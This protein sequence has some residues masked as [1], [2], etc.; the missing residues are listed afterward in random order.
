MPYHCPRCGRPYTT[1]A[2]LLGHLNRPRTSCVNLDTDDL[3]S[4]SLPITDDFGIFNTTSAMGSMYD[5]EPGSTHQEEP[6][7]A[8]QNSEESGSTYREE[9]VNVAHAWEARNTFMGNFDLDD[10][11]EERKKNLYYPFASK[12]EW[13]IAAFLL[14]SGMS[15]ALIDDFLKLQFVSSISLFSP[16]ILYLL[17]QLP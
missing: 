8:H 12:E 7:L 3:V 5:E 1:E 11:A 6:A 15:M 13:E 10:F 2:K 9:F 14:R 16:I 17:R 4:I